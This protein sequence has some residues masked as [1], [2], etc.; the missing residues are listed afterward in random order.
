MVEIAGWAGYLWGWGLVMILPVGTVVAAL[1][2]LGACV[3][4][5]KAVGVAFDPRNTR[6][7]VQRKNVKPVAAPKPSKKKASPP[8]VHTFSDEFKLPEAPF[9]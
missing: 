8:V 7:V 4:V 1:C 6:K 5:Y 9:S 3:N 2:L